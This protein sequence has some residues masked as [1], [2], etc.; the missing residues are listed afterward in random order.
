MDPEGVKKALPEI[1]REINADA[2]IKSPASLPVEH[3]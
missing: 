1:A 2:L 3:G